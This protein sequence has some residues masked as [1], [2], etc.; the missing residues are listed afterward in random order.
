MPTYEYCCPTCGAFEAEQKITAPALSRCPTCD[1]EVKR[2]IS[3]SS[4][5]LKGSGWYSDG[6][7]SSGGSGKK[8]SAASESGPVGGCGRSECG[9]GGCAGS[10]KGLN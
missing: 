1:A 6:Y 3:K 8:S 9:T 2:L 7:G 10:A 4:F 5:K